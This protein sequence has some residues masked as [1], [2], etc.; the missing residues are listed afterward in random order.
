MLRIGV[1]VFGLFYSALSVAETPTLQPAT[2]FKLTDYRGQLVYLDF[3]ASWCPPCRTS[4]PWLNRMQ[5][6]YRDQGLVVIGINNDDDADELHNFLQQVPV[7]FKLVADPQRV[8]AK[9]YRTT[10]LPYSLLIAPDGRILGTHHGFAEAQQPQLENVIT[11]ALHRYQAQ[12]QAQ[13]SNS[14]K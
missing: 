13:P 2:A 12:L 11:R 8:L 7:H 5:A 9:R 14:T 1:L 10:G 6:K 3:W 4:I